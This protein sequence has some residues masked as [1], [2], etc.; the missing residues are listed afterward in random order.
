MYDCDY[1]IKKFDRISENRWC[2]FENKNKQGQCCAYG[3]CGTDYSSEGN[4]LRELDYKF[5]PLLNL[6]WIGGGRYKQSTKL[7]DINNGLYAEY[8]Q[9]T[10]K[11]RILAALY[12]IKRM[13][14]PQYEDVTKSLAVLP[15]DEM[16]DIVGQKQ[17]ALI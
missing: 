4:G 7:A 1:F 11:Q 15:I 10:P 8:Q 12:D 6:T 14:Q 3:H 17:K 16:S 5:T 13:Q 2:V 9:P